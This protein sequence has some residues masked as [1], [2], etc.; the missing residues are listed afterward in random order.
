MKRF[1]YR[2][3]IYYSLYSRGFY[4]TVA[5]GWRG[6]GM[7]YLLV[8]LALYLLF[9]AASFTLTFDPQDENTKAT[10]S[11][12]AAALDL[13]SLAK[14]MPEIT[15]ENG[16]ARTD[17]QQPHTIY[18]RNGVPEIIIDTTGNTKSLRESG[19]LLL[20]GKDALYRENKEGLTQEWLKFDPASNTHI[21][22][23]L[24]LEWVYYIPLF[25]MPINLISLFI[26]TSLMAFML[27]I[28]GGLLNQILRAGLRYE[29]LVRL[30]AVTATPG[31]VLECIFTLIGVQPF[32]NPPLVFFILHAAYLY[33]AVESC[34]GAGRKA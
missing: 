34:K 10:N 29:D 15:I 9:N 21:N 4:R 14:Q 23:E 18:D 28:V 30:A 6:Y 5:M 1:N 27:G 22:S 17:V 26:Y 7:V 12:N 24:L 13:A 19:A 11:I 31:L 8:I 20:L 16:V 32:S 2:N 25:I 3:A 33:H